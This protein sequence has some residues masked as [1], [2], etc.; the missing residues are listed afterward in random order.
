MEVTGDTAVFDYVG[1]TAMTI[2]QNARAEG[3]AWPWA[4]TLVSEDY[5]RTAIVLLHERS[6][7]DGTGSLLPYEMQVL[8]QRTDQPVLLTGCCRLP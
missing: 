3:R 4:M 2:P 8:T 1:Q 6:C 7:D 5:Q